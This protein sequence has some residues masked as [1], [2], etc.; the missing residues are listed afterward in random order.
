ME[1][2][3]REAE[4]V[5]VKEVVGGSEEPAEEPAEEPEEV[6]AARR[7]AVN[8]AEESTAAVG[9]SDCPSAKWGMD[10][11]AGADGWLEVG[12]HPQTNPS[13]G[14]VPYLVVAAGCQPAAAVEATGTRAEA[15]RAEAARAEAARAEAARVEAARAEAAART[16][17]APTPTGGVVAKAWVVLA[18]PLSRPPWGSIESRKGS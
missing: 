5:A 17:A 2:E 4:V 1:V 15:A 10:A 13:C 8:R 12:S 11:E 7:V 3:A 16:V 18:T 14:G 6:V 9:R